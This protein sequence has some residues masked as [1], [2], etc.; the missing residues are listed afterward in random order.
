MMA[1]V[2]AVGQT[3]Y[4]PPIPYAGGQAAPPATQ[5]PPSSTNY[6]GQGNGAWE[7][8]RLVPNQDHQA[9][10]FRA[11]INSPGKMRFWGGGPIRRFFTGM[12][13]GIPDQVLKAYAQESDLCRIPSMQ[14]DWARLLFEVGIR[15]PLELAQYAGEDIGAKIQR[16][17][18]FAAMAAK[19]IELAASE[20]RGY[21]PPSF[22]EL[23][24]VAHTARGMTPGVT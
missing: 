4:V 20:G 15:S 6:G 19:A 9:R 24:R 8:S 13:T 1:R 14:A 16:G 10:L 3:Q 23:G 11:G 22:E 21:S 2:G 17:A 7:L 18:L 5:P 12:F